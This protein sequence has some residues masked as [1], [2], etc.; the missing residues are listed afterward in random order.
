MRR[1]HRPGGGVAAAA[2]RCTWTSR[3][4]CAPYLTVPVAAASPRL[5]HLEW[6][7]DHVRIEQRLFDGCPDPTDAHLTPSD[8]PG[9][10][11]TLKHPPR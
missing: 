3:G 5:R 1:L 6:F 10:G 2:T 8:A 4:H 11:L 9:H 7:H